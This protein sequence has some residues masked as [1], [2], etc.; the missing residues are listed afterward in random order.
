MDL[1]GGKWKPC[2]I[3]NIHNGIKRPSDLQRAIPYASRRSITLQLNELEEHGIIKKQIFP[4]LPPK[5][6]YE[7]TEFGHCILP[8]TLQMER[9]GNEHKE[10][11]FAMLDSNSNLDKEAK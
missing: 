11:Y 8:L 9:W 5:V 1:I 3:N 2:L 6:E 4:V 10:R 7:L